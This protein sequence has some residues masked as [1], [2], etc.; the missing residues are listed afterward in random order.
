MALWDLFDWRRKKEPV[1]FVPVQKAVEQY[2]NPKEYNKVIC[3]RCSH[4]RA[5]VKG[6]K[7]KCTRCKFKWD[8]QKEQ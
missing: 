2:N 6:D 3:P 5:R 1:K 4:K 8:I 7:Y